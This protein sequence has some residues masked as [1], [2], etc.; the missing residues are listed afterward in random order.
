MAIIDGSLSKFPNQIDEFNEV[1]DLDYTAHQKAER[2]TELKSKASLSTAEQNEILQLTTELRD[3]LI[4][5]QSWNRMT[6]ALYSTQ[7]FFNSEVQGFIKEKQ[8]TWD[9]YIRQFTYVGEWVENK[10]YKFQNLVTA[11][12]GDLYLCR[13]DHTSSATTNP[14]SAGGASTWVHASLRGKQGEPS[15]SIGYKGEW[16]PTASYVIGD[17]VSASTGV[18][19]GLLYYAKRAN[20]GKNPTTSPDDWVLYNQLYVNSTPPRNAGKGVHF[21]EVL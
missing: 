12:N 16:N 13:A 17:G 11:S 15:L 5:A 6:S 10:E 20:T 19:N 4:N 1:F 8:K 14:L 3:N 2:L 21:I 7:K 18:D 9:S